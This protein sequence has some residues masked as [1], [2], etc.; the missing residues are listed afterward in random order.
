MCAVLLALSIA[1][2]GRTAVPT[3]ARCAIAG[4]AAAVRDAEEEGLEPQVHL[5]Q[6]KV[7][8]AQ[9]GSSPLDLWARADAA[10]TAA[11]AGFEEEALQEHLTFRPQGTSRM[12][13]MMRIALFIFSLSAFG[14]LYECLAHW[15]HWSRF[16]SCQAKVQRVHDSMQN[17]GD[18]SRLCP[19]C[20][21][22]LSGCASSKVTF[23]CG[24][25]FHFRC[26]NDCYKS[27]KSGLCPICDV[28]AKTPDT[29]P[30][31]GAGVDSASISEGD[32]DEAQAGVA[33]QPAAGDEAQYF[34]LR[35]LQR[36]YP[37]IVSEECVR[38]WASR[39]TEI[40]LSELKCPSYHSTLR[41]AK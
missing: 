18:K 14:G 10:A 15:W 37:D 23:L 27:C 34:I 39:H 29:P 17:P 32:G 2:D 9:L 12:Y 16:R 41:R 35:T 24:H 21:D 4:L 6:T 38:R 22:Y 28:A 13:F 30:T 8:A 7:Q 40:W 1:V 19:Y 11:A 25:S 20:L 33:E 3:S 5:L 36:R 31:S 26:M